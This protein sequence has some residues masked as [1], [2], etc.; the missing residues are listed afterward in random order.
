[1][2]PVG[3]PYFTKRARQLA[4]PIG[5]LVV[6]RLALYKS[7]NDRLPGHKRFSIQGQN[8]TDFNA[9]NRGVKRLAVLSLLIFF[10]NPKKICYS[11]NMA[12]RQQ[13]ISIRHVR[14]IVLKML[15]GPISLMPHVRMCHNCGHIE[16]HPLLYCN[17]CPSRLE[18]P[19]T[20]RMRLSRL[21]GDDNR[22]RFGWEFFGDDFFVQSKLSTRADRYEAI[23]ELAIR[24]CKQLL[25]KKNPPRQT[26]PGR[27]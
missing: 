12:V 27:D 10:N 17:K 18:T 6:R 22:S 11:E 1:M 15:D 19:V 13:S 23:R 16:A 14:G 24:I 8:F 2:E 5:G 4:M 20:W 7:D 25:D 9:A 3:Q 26:R 21:S